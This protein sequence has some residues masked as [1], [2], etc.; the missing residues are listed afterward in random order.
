[1]IPMST[2]TNHP[3]KSQLA[4]PRKGSYYLRKTFD[5]K[6][7]EVALGTNKKNAESRAIRFI[8]TAEKS[9]F[10]TAKE[11][12]HGKPV[13]KAGCNPTFDEFEKLYRE[14]CRQSANAPRIKTINKNLQRFKFIMNKLKVST[15][16][17]IDKNQLYRK[18]FEG[19]D[20]PTPQQQRTFASAVSCASGCFKVSALNF[21]A[22]KG[23]PIQNPFKGLEIAKPKV[24]QYV[25]MPE[26][27]RKK[28][29]SDCQTDQLPCETM[30]VLM[31]LGIGMRISEINASIPEWFSKQ[32]E[33]VTVH[34]K[35]E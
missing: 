30:I 6:Q 35:E 3:P 26:E 2:K 21:Y 16:A 5:G 34:I 13:I 4:V 14:Y 29:W 27:L 10:D 1:M 9:G 31:A 7:R 23:I 12:L 24:K 33:N 17:K 18:W 25:P 19:N 22:S 20:S 15:I 28:I 11:E 8:A 32:A